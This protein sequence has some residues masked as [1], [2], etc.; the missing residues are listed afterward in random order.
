[1]RKTIAVVEMVSRGNPE[2]MFARAKDVHPI[3]PKAKKESVLKDRQSGVRRVFSRVDVGTS[4][5]RLNADPKIVD[6]VGL[7]VESTYKHCEREFKEQ[8]REVVGREVMKL[9]EELGLSGLTPERMETL[10]RL[11]DARMVRCIVDAWL[12]RRDSKNLLG[13]AVKKV[14]ASKGGKG[15]VVTDLV[16]EI[17]RLLKNKQVHDRESLLHNI[18]EAVQKATG[19]SSGI[20]DLGGGDPLKG[21]GFVEVIQAYLGANAL[22]HDSLKESELRAIRAKIASGHSFHLDEDGRKWLDFMATC[23]LDS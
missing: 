13:V 14:N 6:L 9:R 18:E 12:D 2:V 1:M 3:E 4:A 15:D 20:G 22:I 21:R 5:A 19:Q 16:F 17:K 11:G 10:D 23:L 7:H 8:M